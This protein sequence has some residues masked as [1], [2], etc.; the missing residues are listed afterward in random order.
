MSFIGNRPDSFGYSSTSY[1]H[2][3]GTGSQTVYTLSRNVTS[4]SDIFV[5][6]NNVPQD[7][8]VAYYVSNLTTLTFTSAPSASILGNIVVVYRNFVQSGLALGA[9]AVTSFAIAPG[10]VQA[11]QISSVSNT[12]ITGQITSTQLD[13]GT[14]NGTGAILVPSGTTAQRP[15]ANTAG[16]IRY[17]TTLN[18]LESAN[19]TAWANVGS[20]SASSSSS[21]ANLTSLTGNVYISAA[22]GI[23]DSSNATGGLVLPTGTTAQRPASAANGTI[24]W[25]TSNSV[26]EIYVSGNTGWY[27]LASTTYAMEYLAVAGGGGGGGW[28]AGGGGG[29]GGVLSA[30]GI[31]ISPGQTYAVAVGAGGAGGATSVQSGSGGNS[32]IGSLVTS[33]GGGNGE[34][35]GLGSAGGNGGSGGGGCGGGGGPAAGN[36]G[37][38]GTAGQ[39]YAGGY[40]WLASGA[41]GGGAGGGAGAVGGNGSNATGGTGGAGVSYT[42]WATATGTGATGYYGGGGGGDRYGSGNS[43]GGSGGGGYG[44]NNSSNGAGGSTNT[45]GGGGGGL[46]GGNGGS[47]LVII[48]YYGTQRGTGGTVTQ[49]GGYTYHTY[50]S[51][52]NFIA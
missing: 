21:A 42:T 41:D 30:S 25:N 39:G 49:Y 14:A 23:V 15:A 47:G 3:N 26:M 16:Y 33:V 18:S 51:S 6:V 52:G 36:P 31:L 10:A 40:G 8:G 9:N 38:S 27:T 32:T 13:I 44:G 2:F 45:G 22:G 7:P 19:G 11:Y 5:T 50:T 48:R 46:S 24:R 29:A 12:S 37:G 17:N 1:D 4:N 43:P 34:T 35:Q 20:G 28:N